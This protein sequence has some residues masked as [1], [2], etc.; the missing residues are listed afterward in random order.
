MSAPVDPSESLALDMEALTRAAEALGEAT[1]R[2]HRNHY[3]AEWDDGDGCTI[4][5]QHAADVILAAEN[6]HR[7]TR[8]NGMATIA[9][10][11]CCPECGGTGLE[12]PTPDKESP[13]V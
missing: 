13:D 10:G 2:G 12:P 5:W 3:C 6:L 11:D 8:C 9:G 7:C 4:C 1:E